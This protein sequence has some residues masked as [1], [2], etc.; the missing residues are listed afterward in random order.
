MRRPVAGIRFI[1]TRR[2]RD[3]DAAIMTIGAS[4]I[5]AHSERV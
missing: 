5:G 1:E 3:I 4:A 2:P